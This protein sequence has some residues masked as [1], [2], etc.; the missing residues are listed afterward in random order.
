MNHPSIQAASELR[1]AIGQAEIAA[2]A[3]RQAGLDARAAKLEEYIQNA[4]KLRFSI[5]VVA[6]AKRG[7]STLI[8]GLLGRKDD[9]LAPIDRY[10]ATNVVSCF[11]RSPKE[12]ARVL[13]QRDTETSPGKSISID[14][15]K[16][17]A[18][19]EYNP[20]N[21]KGVKIIEVVGPYESLGEDVVLVDTPGADNALTEIHDVV[22]LEFLPKL[23]AVIFL[24][25]ADDPIVAS[26]MELLRQIRKNDVRK[27]LFATNKVDKVDSEELQQGYQQ[28]RKALAEAG[29][30]DCPIFEISAKIFHET[31]EEPGTRQLIQAV[32]ETI[33]EGRAGIIAERLRLLTE[34]YVNEASSEIQCEIENSQLT[35]EEIAQ[36]RSQLDEVRRNLEDNRAAMEARFRS[37]WNAA[38]DD[39][40]DALAPL[41]RKLVADYTEIVEG[42]A[43][44]KL[45]ELGGMIHTDVIKHLDEQLD[46]HMRQLSDSLDSATR[47]LQVNVLETLGISVREADQLIT[48]QKS[49]VDA[50][51]VPLA[52][53]PA[54]V[55]AALVGTLPGMVG[56]AI[57]STAPAAAA[58]TW[59]PVTWVAAAGGTLVGGTVSLTGAAV[60]V[61]LSPVAMIGTPVLIG[62]AGLKIFNSWKHKIYKKKNELSIGVK[63]LITEAIAE[64]RRNVRKAR[65]QGD[66][67]LIE[68]KENSIAK[69]STAQKELGELERN[70]PT[71]ERIADLRQAERL[72]ERL[73]EPK[74]LPESKDNPEKGERLFP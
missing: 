31:G 11:A 1:E 53:A 38:F 41:Q 29:F 33:H 20:G 44:L 14:Q 2:D 64:T 71:P 30:G 68:F 70:R 73:Q 67:I 25:S 17:Y 62:Y 26:E 48:R 37:S 12:S 15:I 22:L 6:Q 5:G 10:P 36:K 4:R 35:V 27:L 47:A 39:F 60:T 66:Q 56:A 46:P 43:A 63:D 50:F 42:C 3:F 72:I 51:S 28:N 40:E 8:N 59:N 23:D 45:D 61:L 16:D 49:L 74:A 32:E 65:N 54:L 57:L 7:K 52:G 24:V 21:R 19:E 69:I 34:T 18:C 55:G 13:F 58:I 9:V